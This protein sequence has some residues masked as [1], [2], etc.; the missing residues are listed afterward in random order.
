MT[1]SLL[2]YRADVP[3]SPQRYLDDL[4][5]APAASSPFANM[6]PDDANRLVRRQLRLAGE[7]RT[8]LPSFF[9]FTFREEDNQQPIRTMPHQ[10]VV[11]EF[12]RHFRF[13]VVRLP[14][15]F[16]KT[17]CMAAAGLYDIGRNHTERGAFISAAEA[18]AAKPLL[19][20][21]T[22]IESSNE[23]RLVF[24]TLR[25]TQR[26]AEP[27]TQN[28][29]TVDR[30][31]GIRDPTVIA[32]G[33]DS[34]RLP[35]ARLTFANIDDVLDAENT[36]TPDARKKTIGWI[37]STVLSR[38]NP[39]KGRC[40][41]TNTPWHPD[42]ATYALEK[43]GWPSLNMDCWGGIWF[44]NADSFDSNELRAT[45]DAAQE[46]LETGKIPDRCR[47]IAHDRPAFVEFAARLLPDKSAVDEAAMEPRGSIDLTNGDLE[48]LVP[49]WPERWPISALLEERGTMGGGSEWA[50]TKEIKT[51]SDEDARVKR[52]WIEQC[53]TAAQARGYY[54]PLP[55]W[56]MGAAYT[57]VDLAFGRKKKSDNVCIF[58]FAVLEDMRRL[59]LGID[60]GKFRGKDMLNRI[61]SHHD[62]FESI[63]AIESNAAQRLLR[64]WGLDLDISMRLRDFTT[65]KNKIAPDFGVESIF[66]ELE[67]GA[68]LIPCDRRGNVDAN[69]QVWID[70]CLD[71]RRDA[72]T[73]DALMASWMAR[74]QARLSGSLKKG[75]GFWGNSGA[76]AQSGIMAR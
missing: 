76:V 56:E 27:W 71:Y 16:S 20:T 37:K 3:A 74:E 42:D 7:S 10:R 12:I 25:P 58:T 50:R 41:F 30:P 28:A 23:L 57:G 2:P 4:H 68:W 19:L 38:F 26:D 49:L 35:G 48:E 34:Q 47:L 17:F 11:F 33:L 67:N 69:I 54:A 44:K 55:R 52:E 8:N 64:E 24:P 9:E 6:S 60:Y 45:R 40:A 18:Q 70:D 62:K 32:V 14:T 1:Q 75:K 63:V 39:G 13:C 36:A 72:H 5:T 53:K 15:N 51:R 59:I 29:I 21:R 46:E 65:A 43:V 31:M 61:K 73:G 22:Y 66:L